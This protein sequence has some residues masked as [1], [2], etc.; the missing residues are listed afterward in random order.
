MHSKQPRGA[1]VYRTSEL[2]LGFPVGERVRL[3][4]ASQTTA[5]IRNRYN[6]VIDMSGQM[7]LVGLI[8]VA[9]L[10]VAALLG[11]KCKGD[12]A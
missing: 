2:G 11:R 10:A 5:R 3:R 1:Y 12:D 6:E 4:A 9:S 8:F 7:L